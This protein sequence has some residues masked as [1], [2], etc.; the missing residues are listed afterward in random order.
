MVYE[1]VIR[2]QDK[3]IW[4]RNWVIWVHSKWHDLKTKIIWIHD[5]LI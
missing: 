5:E 4:L 2:I 3:V 1:L